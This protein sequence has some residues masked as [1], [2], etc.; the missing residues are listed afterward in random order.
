M[1]ML[2]PWIARF[3]ELFHK[4]QSDRELDAELTSHLEMHVADN[5]RA[6]MTEEEARRDA[7]IKLGGVEQTKESY[8]EQR[9]FAWLE[10]VV[11]DLR[12]GLRM[13]R[14]NPGFTAIA[15]LTLALGIGA[16]TIVSSVGYS[17]LLNALPYKDFDRAAVIKLQNLAN[18]GGWKGRDF[19][20]PEEFRAFRE[21]NHVF[22]EMI[23]Y[24]GV[25]LWYDDGKFPRYLPVGHYVTTNTFDFLGVQ[26]LIGRTA[27]VRDE[28]SVVA[29]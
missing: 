14:K 26:P 9:G 28:L 1:R 15:V 3:Q 16:A 4:Q 12:F 5:V 10:T 6:G 23:A 19:F 21:Q 18:V 2:G 29:N 24:G 20:S 13:L 8:R 17:V 25:R 27:R 11:Q 7:R 22:E